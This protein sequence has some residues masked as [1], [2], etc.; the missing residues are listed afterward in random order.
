MKK[1]NNPF[2]ICAIS[3]AGS[4]LTAF[5]FVVVLKAS[6]P[7]TDLAYGQSVFQ[8]FSDPFVEVIFTQGALVSGLVTF[9]VAYFC[10]RERNLRAAVPIVF[11]SVWFGTGIFTAL[12]GPAG[13]LV[14]YLILLASLLFC[15][16]YDLRCLRYRPATEN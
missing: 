13:L 10:L 9:P 15:R 4:Y 12:A 6:L 8:I 14:S 11:G 7:P 2:L 5:V 3:L 16:F 1:R